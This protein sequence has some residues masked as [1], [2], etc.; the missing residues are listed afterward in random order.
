MCRVLPISLWRRKKRYILNFQFLRYNKRHSEKKMSLRTFVTV[1]LVILK[2]KWIGIESCA[3]F[4]EMANVRGDS[5]VSGYPGLSPKIQDLLL[6][7]IDDWPVYMKFIIKCICQSEKY[8]LPWAVPDGSKL[9]FIILMR[10]KTQWW[11]CVQGMVIKPFGAFLKTFG[12]SAP[13]AHP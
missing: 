5:R 6:L 3:S 1:T 8:E 12:A 10:M 11:W 4:D 9:R 2:R 7:H 13:L